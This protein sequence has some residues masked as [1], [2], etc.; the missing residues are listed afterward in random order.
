MKLQVYLSNHSNYIHIRKLF[1]SMEHMG[2][3][4]SLSIH[5]V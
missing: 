5:S 2:I 4:D 1:I 3:D